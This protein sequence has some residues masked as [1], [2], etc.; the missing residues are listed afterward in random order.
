M[1]VEQIKSVIRERETKKG[2]FTTALWEH[3]CKCKKA[4]AND[5]LYKTS[6]AIVRLGV[7]YDNIGNV[8][9]KRENGELPKENQGLP[10]GEWEYFPYLIKH[11]GKNYLRMTLTN[12]NPVKSRYCLNGKMVTYDEIEHMLLS[13][14]KPKQ[15]SKPDVITVDIENLGHL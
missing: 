5:K 10:W 3:K 1:T 14:E 7:T 13:S 2:C 8:K 15:G 6:V 12:G 4:Y 9:E 11:N